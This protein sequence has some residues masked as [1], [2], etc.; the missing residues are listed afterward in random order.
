MWGFCLI[1]STGWKQSRRLLEPV[2]D[3]FMVGVLDIPARGG[4]VLLD[5]VL[6]GT[7]KLI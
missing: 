7:E 3:N 1:L 6:T 4:E 5:P 2:D